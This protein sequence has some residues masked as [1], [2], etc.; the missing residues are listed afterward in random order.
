MLSII[1]DGVTAEQ[2]ADLEP[3]LLGWIRSD[4]ELCQRIKVNG[5]IEL[6]KVSSI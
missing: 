2:I 1:K 5:I 6:V 4:P 3:N